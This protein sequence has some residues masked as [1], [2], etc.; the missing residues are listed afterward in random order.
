MFRAGFRRHE[1]VIHVIFREFAQN[2]ARLGRP[3][4]L[5]NE[6]GGHDHRGATPLVD[7]L[8]HCPKLIKIFLEHGARLEYE[9]A[10]TLEGSNLFQCM[11]EKLDNVRTFIEH[12]ANIYEP[13]KF[14]QLLDY[15]H[16]RD[17]TTLLHR[18]CSDVKSPEMTRFLLEKGSDPSIPDRQ[19]WT[20]LHAA[21]HHGTVE[22]VGILVQA[23]PH[24]LSVQAQDGQTPIAQARTNGNASIVQLLERLQRLFPEPALSTPVTNN[25]NH[26]NHFGVKKRDKIDENVG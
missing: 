19:G 10:D 8:W 2:Q 25:Q 22:T 11:L 20:P 6:C 17:R 15:Q 16:T 5:L 18:A 24:G 4:D 7:V 21:A 14:R 26:E 1:E 13:V 9:C 23:W 3:T 12:A